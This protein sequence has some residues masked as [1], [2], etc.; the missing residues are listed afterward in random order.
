MSRGSAVTV[1]LMIR[2]SSATHSINNSRK[3]GN[4]PINGVKR[5]G[6]RDLLIVMNDSSAGES[7]ADLVQSMEGAGQVAT[8]VG[9]LT[10]SVFIMRSC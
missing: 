7:M 2:G 1:K 4:S 5:C 6:G 10:L 9:E 8:M 3:R